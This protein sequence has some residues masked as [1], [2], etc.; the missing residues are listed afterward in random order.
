MVFRHDGLNRSIIHYTRA[1][2]RTLRHIQSTRAYPA[3]APGRRNPSDQRRKIRAILRTGGPSPRWCKHKVL[4]RRQ[5]YR[6]RDRAL[7]AGNVGMGEPNHIRQR[8]IE[9]LWRTSPTW[10]PAMFE[11]DAIFA[12]QLTT[13]VF[14]YGSAIM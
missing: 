13:T 9:R 8:P 1:Q 5:P 3:A 11:L 2:G 12:E 14:L 6:L 7:E 4:R 10:R